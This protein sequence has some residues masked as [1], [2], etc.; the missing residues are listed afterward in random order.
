[1]NDLLFIQGATLGENHAVHEFD[2][3]GE[4]RTSF[5]G[6][7]QSPNRLINYALAPG[8]LACDP[9]DRIIIYA[10]AGGLGE[11]HGY[12]LQGTLVWLTTITGYHPTNVIENDRGYAVTLPEA[13]FHRLHSLTYVSPRTVV[14]QFAFSSREA[15][16]KG[17]AYTQLQTVVLQGSSGLGAYVGDSVPALAFVGSSLWVE[18]NSDPYPQI[19]LHVPSTVK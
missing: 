17:L 4:Y 8:Y 19:Q 15:R 7:Y 14:A 9:A 13:G 11:I 10:P 16:M 6:T 5:G 12:N 2:L 1:M 3:A 18:A